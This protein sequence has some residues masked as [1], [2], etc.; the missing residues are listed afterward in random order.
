MTRHLVALV[1]ALFFFGG[2]AFTSTISDL[3]YLKLF[4]RTDL[5]HA[6]KS[7]QLVNQRD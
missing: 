3:S 2:L 7:P 6:L 5:T 1:F 4:P